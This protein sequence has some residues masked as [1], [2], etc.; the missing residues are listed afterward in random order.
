MINT[1]WDVVIVVCFL[2]LLVCWILTTQDKI[3]VGG[4]GPPDS[5]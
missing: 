1:I 4:F 2:V 5:K 3:S